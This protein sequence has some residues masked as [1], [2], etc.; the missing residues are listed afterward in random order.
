MK[1]TMCVFM[2][3]VFV[4][5]CVQA[6][7]A[8]PVS[9][10]KAEAAKTPKPPFGGTI[11]VCRNIITDDDP[12]SFKSVVAIG[13]GERKMFDRRLNRSP[14]V[15]AYLFTATFD[16]GQTMEIRV[17][18]EFGADGAMAQAKKYLPYIGQM[19]FTLRKD[20]Q[21]VLIH[22]G[23]KG[24]GGGGK[25]ILIHTDMG[26]SY[27]RGGILAETLCHEASHTSLDQTHSA[28]KNWLAAQKADGAFISGY[29][30]GN[31][32][33]EDVAESYLL[34]FAVRYKPHRIDDKLREKI[35]K[36]IPNRIAYF[37][38]QNLP[39]HP[40]APL[41]ELGRLAGTDV[42]NKLKLSD[43]Q[44]AKINTLRLSLIAQIKKLEKQQAK[45]CELERKYDAKSIK[46]LT[47]GQRKILDGLKEQKR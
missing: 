17:N 3:I 4:C 8:K 42:Q 44:K 2:G 34:Y 33:R 16:D 36:T 46:L 15:N 19:P 31:P 22:K 10:P 18:P 39:M 32:R 26:D 12:T 7:S 23:K 43:D 47:A 40:V 29:A 30:R 1:R 21:N 14:K 11:F 13:R 28:D 38:A 6:K 45:I 24:F 37:D 27:I 20:V 25:G 9:S 35:T 5:V 41:G